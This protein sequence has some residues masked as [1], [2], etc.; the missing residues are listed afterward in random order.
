MSMEQLKKWWGRRKKDYRPAG[1]L[2]E[3]VMKDAKEK[4]CDKLHQDLADKPQEG[5]ETGHGH[6][7]G[8]GQSGGNG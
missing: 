6:G 1:Q 5:T 2:G 7:K 3:E 8:Y 4:L